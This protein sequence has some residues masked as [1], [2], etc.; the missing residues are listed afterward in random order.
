RGS[1]VALDPRTGAIRV[2]ASIPDYNPNDVPGRY[3]QLNRDASSPLFNRA[4]QS[5]Y[6]PGS[7]FKVV[8]AAAAIDSGRY[9]PTSIVSGR[10]N[11]IISGV[12][13]QN[14]GGADYGPITL[15]DGLTH[16]VNTVW[17]EVGEKLG[18]GTMF[19][20]MRRFGF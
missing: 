4:T 3:G 17:G 8:T 6:P 2:M 14:D 12:P 9:S 18:K 16:S 10:N 1:V 7:T 5:G 13:L 20:Y 15:T 19:K 11:K